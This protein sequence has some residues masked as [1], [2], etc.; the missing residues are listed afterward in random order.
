MPEPAP[1]AG[2]PPLTRAAFGYLLDRRGR[3]LMVANR[4]AD[5]GVMW[6]VP[7]GGL[8]PDETHRDCVVREFREEVGLAVRVTADCGTI[9]RHKPAW[10]LNLRARF[11]RV[12][13]LEGAPRIDPAEEHVVDFAWRGRKEIAAFPGVILGR[14]YILHWLDH[15]EAYPQDFV[16]AAHEE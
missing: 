13:R 16:M 2:P 7:G 15:P 3:L 8:D 14:A 1:D 4:Y 5:H 10:N 12:E 11:F 9:A 6:G